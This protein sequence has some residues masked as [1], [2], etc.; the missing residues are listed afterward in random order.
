M[1]T[2]FFE[3]NGQTRGIEI[4]D[5]SANSSV[6]KNIQADPNDENQISAPLAGVIAAIEV[7]PGDSIEAGQ[8]LFSLEAMKMQTMVTAQKPGKVKSIELEAGR[9][10]SGGDLVLALEV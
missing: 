3:L 8:T 5:R 6:K 7:K 10:V 9:Q 4:E 2:I 1:R